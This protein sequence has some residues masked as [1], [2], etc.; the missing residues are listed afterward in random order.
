MR[1]WLA[2]HSYVRVSPS[3][4][5]ALA[6]TRTVSPGRICDRSTS[7]LTVGL[8]LPGGGGG[9]G[10]ATAISRQAKPGCQPIERCR[11]VQLFELW[12]SPRSS[13]FRFQDIAGRVKEPLIEDT[14]P[15]TRAR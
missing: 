10:A 8:L 6:R 12:F 3:G 7:Q 11:P 13:K 14:G 2:L 15:T 5:E 9:G 1:P 4:S